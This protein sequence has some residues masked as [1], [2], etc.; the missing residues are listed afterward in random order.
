MYVVH[1]FLD[2]KVSIFFK[3]QLSLI[4][5]HHLTAINNPIV[6]VLP[7]PIQFCSW[8]CFVSPKY[9]VVKFS[10]I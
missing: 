1:S 6:V 10:S 3:L 9:V 4:H 8:L 7:Q 2:N 5:I